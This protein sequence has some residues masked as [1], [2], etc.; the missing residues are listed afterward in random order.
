MCGIA[1]YFGDD[2][3]AFEPR[4][5]SALRMLAHRGPDDAGSE[6]FRGRAHEAVLGST[7]LAIVDIS[8]A[9]H[10]PMPRDGGAQAI[11]FNGEVYNT[12]SLRDDLKQRGVT[13]RSATDTEVLLHGLT[14]DGPAFLDLVDGMYALAFWDERDGGSLLLARDRF[15]EKPLL[16]YAMDDGDVVFASEMRALRD[17]VGRPLDVDPSALA[18]I[19]TWGYPSPDG[20]IFAGVHKVAP[21]HWV[22][23]G[24]DVQHGVLGALGSTPEIASVR[25]RSTAHALLFETLRTSVAQRMIADVPVGV[26]LSGGIDSAAVA[27]LAAHALP[28]G[29]RLNTYTVGYPGSRFSELEPARAVAQHLGTN[30]HEIPLSYEH[31]EALPFVAASLGEPIG[32][33]AALPTYF[34]SVAARESS[35]VLLTGEGSDEVLFGYPRYAMHDLADGVARGAPFPTLLSKLPVRPFTRLRRAALAAP[36]R[37]EAWKSMRP[38]DF[39]IARAAGVPDGPQPAGT[40]GEPP[41]D[42][43]ARRARTDDVRRW[44]PESVLARLDRMTMAASIEARAPFLARDVVR[45]GLHLSDRDLRRFPYGKRPLRAALVA[46]YGYAKAWGMK[47]GFLVPVIDWL[48]GPLRATTEDVF[49][50]GRLAARGWFPARALRDVGDAVLARRGDSAWVAWTLVIVELW[51]RAHVDGSWPQPPLPPAAARAEARGLGVG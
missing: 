12:A 3:R 38:Q 2:A 7:R 10:M 34:L 17:L 25:G 41:S 40:R 27:A 46:E 4:V 21:G 47:R 16:V 28:R 22:R 48:S 20:S 13:F 29:E 15:G 6:T 42:R 5:A 49:F 32:D 35:T 9:G 1:G 36:E 50:G 14:I 51:A 45:L 39:G 18:H 24:R 31:L 11:A 19:L 33:A 26:F 8:P 43:G 23:Y 44:M 30:H 37:D